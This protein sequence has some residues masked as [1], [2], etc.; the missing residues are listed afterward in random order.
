M[1]LK[2]LK[3]IVAAT[4]VLGSVAYLIYTLITNDYESKYEEVMISIM[5]L[6]AI[7][8]A[9]MHAGDERKWKQIDNDIQ[10]KIDKVSNI[11]I[12]SYSSS[13][14]CVEALN[15]IVKDGEHIVENASL[16]THTRSKA[17]GARHPVWEHIKSLSKN[18][19]IKFR[20]IIRVD[21]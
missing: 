5:I 17:K 20:Q 13:Q 14:A 15:L 19:K 6:L 2:I 18:K 4:T 3:R 1:F 12:T 21:K 16:D 11:Q 10:Q 9:L 7:D 8:F